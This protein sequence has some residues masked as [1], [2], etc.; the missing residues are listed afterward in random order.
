[1]SGRSA[2]RHAAQPRAATTMRSRYSVLRAARRLQ[3]RVSR[4]SN[5]SGII[6]MRGSACFARA[7]MKTLG[8]RTGI[9]AAAA[10]GKSSSPSRAECCAGTVADSAPGGARCQ[11]EPQ[12]VCASAGSAV[13]LRAP[14]Y[15]C[16]DRRTRDNPKRNPEPHKAQRGTKR[17]TECESDAG[18]L[19]NN[20]P[21]VGLLA[22]LELFPCPANVVPISCGR[23]SRP[24]ASSA[25]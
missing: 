5:A 12:R 11:G 15:R 14:T 10:R 9:A 4:P 13:L 19:S 17:H 24:P 7:F 25:C 21:R 18:P 20:C 2:S 16:P 8:L 22:H 23:R 6:R 3:R 1:M